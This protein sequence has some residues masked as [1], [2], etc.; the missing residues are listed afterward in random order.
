MDAKARVLV[1]DDDPYVVQML[2]AALTDDGYQVDV[3]LLGLAATT[4]PSPCQS[5]TARGFTRRPAS[6]DP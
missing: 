4:A 6:P 5:L 1:V 2:L 3:A